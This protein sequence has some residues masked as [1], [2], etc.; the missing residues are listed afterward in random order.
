MA[1]HVHSK[2]PRKKAIVAAL[3]VK[4]G[5][6]K[7]TLVQEIR[8]GVFQGSCSERRSDGFWTPCGVYEVTAKEA[9]LEVA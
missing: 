5:C 1:K 4:S 7:V 6:T 3:K 9:G 2:D 8:P